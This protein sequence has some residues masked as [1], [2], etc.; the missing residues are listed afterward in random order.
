MSDKNKA[1]LLWMHFIF[2]LSLC[3]SIC[4]S[5]FYFSCLN[6]RLFPFPH[7]V[8]CLSSPFPVCPVCLHFSVVSFF[9][10]QSQSPPV[11]FFFFLCLYFCFWLSFSLSTHAHTDTHAPSYFLIFT[12]SLSHIYKY[13]EIDNLHFIG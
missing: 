4:P 5:H 2:P 13:R 8:G 12:L 1:L 6:H 11:F 10:S 7:I 3:P 9:G